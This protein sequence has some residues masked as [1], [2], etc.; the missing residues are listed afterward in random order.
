MKRIDFLISMARLISENES[1]STSNDIRDDEFLQYFNDGQARLQSLISNARDTSK[2]FVTEKIISAVAGQEEY[3]IPDRILFNKSIEQIEF[4]YDST[5]A[6]YMRLQKCGFYNRKT[7]SSSYPIGYYRR[8]NK[9]YPIPIISSSGGSFR[10]MYERTLDALDVRRGQVSSVAGLTS[11]GFT[12]LVL[13]GAS[14]TGNP[15]TSSSPANLTN[16]DYVCICDKDGTVT[17]RNIPVG[18]FNTS[19]NTLTPSGGYTFS[20]GETIAVG[21]YLTFH[22]YTTTHSQL[23]DDCERYLLAYCHQA[24]LH[25]DSSND[26][27][28]GNDVLERI[29]KDIIASMKKQTG[30][31]QEIPQLDPVEWY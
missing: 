30:E 19:T 1:V 25:R 28:E 31:L 23:P 21:S 17:A 4:S 10:V 29:E 8:Q 16:I 9:F 13:T 14:G 20:T 3:T 27:T 11:T 6:N 5:A 2:I 7:D 22:K 24:I 18:S 12:S 26:W 15:D